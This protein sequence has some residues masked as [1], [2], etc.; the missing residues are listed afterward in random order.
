MF[1]FL[2][3]RMRLSLSPH[4][5]NSVIT[6]PRVATVRTFSVWRTV[7]LS[8]D[9]GGVF[10]FEETGTPQGR[11]GTLEEIAQMAI[12][13]VSDLSSHVTGQ[14]IGVDGGWTAYGYI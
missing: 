1:L 13:L 7:A 12:F 3:E 9:R 11:L 5:Q 2:A 4:P 14:V 10:L 6:R 8:C